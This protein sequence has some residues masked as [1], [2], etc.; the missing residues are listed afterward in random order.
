MMYSNN[1]RNRQIILIKSQPLID[2]MRSSYPRFIYL[3]MKNICRKLSEKVNKLKKW[4][5]CLHY[6][7]I[8]LNPHYMK[9]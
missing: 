5:L 6:P 4:F 8:L 1:F 3:S 7:I 9:K 2:K